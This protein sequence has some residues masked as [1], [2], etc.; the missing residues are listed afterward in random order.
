MASYTQYMEQSGTIKGRSGPFINERMTQGEVTQNFRVSK[1]L[2]ADRKKYGERRDSDELLGTLTDPELS[3]IYPNEPL[4]V[5]RRGATRG[6]KWRF[7][8]DTRATAFSSFN[9][10][11]IRGSKTQEEFEDLFTFV[12][13]SKTPYDFTSNNQPQNGV[14]ARVSGSGTTYNNG[15]TDFYP[16]DLIKWR[17]RRINPEER[18]KDNS[19]LPHFKGIPQHKFTAVMERFDPKDITEFPKRALTWILHP[20]NMGKSDIYLLEPDAETHLTA[21]Q[22]FGI[23]KKASDLSK[24]YTAV[25]TLA[26]YGLITINTPPGDDPLDSTSYNEFNNILNHHLHDINEKGTYLDDTDK[27][28]KLGEGEN[29]QEKS[30]KF[31]WLAYQ[32][33]LLPRDN[34][35]KHLKSSELFVNTLLARVNAGLLVEPH[36]VEYFELNKAFGKNTARKRTRNGKTFDL[37]TIEG[38]LTRNQL[39]A[40]RRELHNFEFASQKVRDKIVG[41]ALNRSAREEYLDYVI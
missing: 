38:L 22:E 29:I 20:E 31:T 16:G 21:E 3:N 10:I 17:L 11:Y 30:K 15:N 9:G 36:D 26:Q 7:P 5:E 25:V 8:S 35:R 37:N 13:F 2:I 18:K 24:I 6:G 12:G 33:G 14:A 39:D 4:F 41:M 34:Y 27:K 28:L 1:Y 32:L 23:S 40:P 19:R